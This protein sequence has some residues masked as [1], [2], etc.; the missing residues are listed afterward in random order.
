MDHACVQSPYDFSWLDLEGRV[1]LI[2]RALLAVAAPSKVAR[3]M[4]EVSTH[5]IS[6]L[7]MPSVGGS[8][9][10]VFYHADHAA[11]FMD[12]G[13]ALLKETKLS[14]NGGNDTLVA[15]GELKRGLYL[16]E[17]DFTGVDAAARQIYRKDPASGEFAALNPTGFFLAAKSTVT[18]KVEDPSSNNHLVLSVGDKEITIRPGVRAH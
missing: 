16:I 8:A 10:R 12:A 6:K 13:W 15:P 4:G 17:Y 9:V 14:E 2:A 11:G 7:G 3:G 5:V 18:L 1:R